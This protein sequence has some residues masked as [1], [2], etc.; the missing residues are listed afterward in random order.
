[1]LTV[2]AMDEIE[3][4]TPKRIYGRKKKGTLRGK[5]PT[6]WRIPLTQREEEML[7]RL[8]HHFDYPRTILG[9]MLLRDAYRE[10]YGKAPE[11]LVPSG[12]E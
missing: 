4:P 6:E 10:L 5:R 11:A 7:Q 1:M 3:D 9:R 8:V 12:G 2:D